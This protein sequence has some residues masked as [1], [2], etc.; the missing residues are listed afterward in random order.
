MMIGCWHLI[1][2]VS[3]SGIAVGRVFDERKWQGRGRKGGK[4]GKF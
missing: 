1:D 4:E 3:E 2:E